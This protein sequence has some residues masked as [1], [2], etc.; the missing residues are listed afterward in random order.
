ML[1]LKIKKESDCDFGRDDTA[2][3][4]YKMEEH[5]QLER[6]SMLKPVACSTFT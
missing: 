6:S 2:Q 3:G 1:G 5:W 4:S